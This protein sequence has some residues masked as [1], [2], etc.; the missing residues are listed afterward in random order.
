MV[1]WSKADCDFLLVFNYRDLRAIVRDWNAFTSAVPLRVPIPPDIGGRNV[2]QLPLESDPPDAT[3][4]RRIIE[5]VF[6]RD[7]AAKI[8]PTVA[9]MADVL[10]D[11]AL[12]RGELEVT[13]SFALP[14]F[15]RALALTLGRPQADATEWLAWGRTVWQWSDTIHQYLP[16]ERMD[17][18]LEKCIDEAQADPGE[19]FFGRIAGAQFHGRPLTREEMLGLANIA[20]AAGRDPAVDVIADGLHYLA[21]NPSVFEALRNSPDM[22]PSAIEELLRYFSPV[23]VLGRTVTTPKTLYGYDLVPGDL[24]GL[25]FAAGNRDPEAF[26]RPHECNLSRRPNRHVAFGHGP[27]TCVGAPLARMLLKVVLTCFT[28][29]VE[30]MLIATDSGEQTAEIAPGLHIRVA[31]THLTLRL[32]RSQPPWT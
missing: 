13:D 26:E 21:T 29:H 28:T 8:E 22:V 19:D 23:H 20:L 17:A 32:T 6:N 11:S 4:Y 27:H 10:M 12:Q 5:E 1:P 15:L 3:E 7:T 14:L 30:T 18:Y 9:V 16:N 2:A 24:I 25:G 31:P